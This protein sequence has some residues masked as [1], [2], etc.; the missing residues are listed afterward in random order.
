MKCKKVCCQSTA[1]SQFNYIQNI[2]ID[3][4]QRKSIYSTSNYCTTTIGESIEIICKCSHVC[5]DVISYN[6]P[7]T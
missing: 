2:I 3:F 1:L 7:N 4:D 6:I 5:N